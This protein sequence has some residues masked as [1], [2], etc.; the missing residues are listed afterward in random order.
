MPYGFS[1]TV[2]LPCRSEP[3]E[4]SEQVNQLT[5][6]ELYEVL[7]EKEKW[8]RI[9]TLAD[10]YEGW[11]DRKLHTPAG[12]A[13]LRALDPKSC[14][15]VGIPLLRLHKNDGSWVFISFGALIPSQDEFFLGGTQYRTSLPVIPPV[16]PWDLARQFLDSPY[17]WGGKS[18]FG[19]DCSGLV[20][21]V[22]RI[23]GTW[24]PRDAWQQAQLGEEIDLHNRQPGDLAFFGEPGKKITHVG[25]CGPGGQIIH[26][27][28]KVR[29]DQ[30]TKDG[31][32]TAEGILSHHHTS[33]KRVQ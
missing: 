4:R 15:T 1:S 2:I 13:E 9:C 3:S 31:I 14:R 27:S 12:D 17:L 23:A 6:G 32:L 5:F 19:I 22:Y 26:A 24:L 20:Q 30:L 28:G 29:T 10:Q 8:I 18:I 11:V 7:E 25:I 33:V 21:L 16:N